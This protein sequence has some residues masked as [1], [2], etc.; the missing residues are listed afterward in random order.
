MPSAIP[1]VPADA[2]IAT[3]TDPGGRYAYGRLL[4]ALTDQLNG[5]TS[6]EHAAALIEQVLEPTDGLLERLAEFFEAAAE[7]AK[8]SDHEDGFDLHYE[9]EDAASTVRGLGEDLHVAVDRMRALSPRSPV[10]QTTR[11]AIAGPSVGLPT[12]APLAPGRTR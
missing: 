9:L 7:K 12:A 3:P 1:A 2:G 4:L 8:E 10:R 11:A 5:A 6:Y